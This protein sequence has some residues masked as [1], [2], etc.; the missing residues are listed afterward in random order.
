MRIIGEKPFE[1]VDCKTGATIILPNGKPAF[2]AYRKSAIAKLISLK[3]SGVIA[4]VKVN[5]SD[6]GMTGWRAR[7][8][9]R[10]SV[11][12]SF[13][14]TDLYKNSDFAKL[15]Y[16]RHS[17]N[18]PGKIAYTASEED[19]FLDKQ[20]VISFRKYLE[21]FFPAVSMQ[22]AEK[23]AAQFDYESKNGC[24]LRFATTMEEIAHVYVNGPSSCMSYSNE[25]H[26]SKVHPTCFYAG[27][28][29]AIAYLINA[30]GK[31]SSRVVTW[32][33][34]KI[35]TTIYGNEALMEK[36]LCEQ[37]YE[38]ASHSRQFEGCRVLL[39]NPDL[40][41]IREKEPYTGD[42]VHTIKVFAKDEKE[43]TFLSS[44]LS[45]QVDV[46]DFQVFRYFVPYCDHPLAFKDIGGIY[47][48]KAISNLEYDA[49][50]NCFVGKLVPNS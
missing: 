33:E 31:I 4:K 17:A 22:E 3:E 13:A 46:G 14:E 48:D 6:A 43:K 18:F 30:R 39:V 12:P 15:H 35:Y 8:E 36:K 44:Y 1:L 27:G 5:L 42:R 21:R 16:I 9:K 28:D 37:G 2:F 10:R 11:K 20:T 19:G 34:K 41:R 26:N 38:R 50:K 24:E 29:L 45:K 23:H 7:E 32:P 25:R 47:S 40:N 49:N